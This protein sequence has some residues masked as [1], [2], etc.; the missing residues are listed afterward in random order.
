MIVDSD[1]LRVIQDLHDALC[2]ELA[3]SKGTPPDEP[4]RTL[5]ALKLLSCAASCER[6]PE[7]IMAYVRARM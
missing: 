7:K 2:A 6:E 3:A 5:V 4:M 1:L